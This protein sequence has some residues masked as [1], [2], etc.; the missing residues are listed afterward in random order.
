VRVVTVG[1]GQVG[2]GVR[3]ADDNIGVRL[4]LSPGVA[5]LAELVGRRD[6]RILLDG[7]HFKPAHIGLDRAVAIHLVADLAIH[8][9]SVGWL[10]QGR[11]R[12]DLKFTD[13]ATGWHVVHRRDVVNRVV[14]LVAGAIGAIGGHHVGI[15]V[16]P[17]QP[18]VQGRVGQC[19]T[20]SSGRLALVGHLRGRTARV[21]GKADFFGVARFDLVGRD[22]RY[23]G[24]Y[25]QH[26]DDRIANL[27]QWR[28]LCEFGIA[29]LHHIPAA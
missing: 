27:A 12:L 1:A 7:R 26:G 4:D 2:V 11:R 5:V 18:L 19:L 17:G 23:G 15:C 28:G 29:G 3:P 16:L 22:N 21:L 14:A 9:V 20:R 13:R 10:D 25:Q 24:C 6:L 8:R